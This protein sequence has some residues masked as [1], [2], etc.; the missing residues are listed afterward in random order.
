MLASATGAL[1][2]VERLERQ[3]KHAEA[4]EVLGRFDWR[5][6]PD[7]CLVGCS[8]LAALGDVSTEAAYGAAAE[9][10][11]DLAEFPYNYGNWLLRTGRLGEALT[12]YQRAVQRSPDHAKAQLNLGICAFNLDKFQLAEPALTRALSNFPDLAE[13]RLILARTCAK[14]DQP[15]RA[16]ALYEQYLINRPRDVPALL[17]MGLL[18]Q[19]YSNFSLALRLVAQAFPHGT[20]YQ[21]AR[22]FSM[23]AELYSSN[24]QP[25]Q[26]VDCFREALKIAP[27]HPQLHFA[28]LMALH[29]V[30]NDDPTEVI[31]AVREFGL[32]NCV[33]RPRIHSTPPDPDRRIRVGL[34]SGSFRR[35]PVGWLTLRAFEN[36]D[37]ERFELVAFESA[38][39]SDVFNKRFRACCSEW[40]QVGR[41][42]DRELADF[43]AGQR[44]D[45]LFELAGSGVGG[46]ILAMAFKP[47][48]IIIK[49]VGNQYGSSG[50]LEIDYFLTDD[51]E[52]PPGF[53]DDFAEELIRMPNGYAVYEPPDYAPAV[54]PLPALKNGFVRFASFNNVSKIN[55]FSV[56]LWARVMNAVPDSQLVLK[57]ISL[58][59]P[60]IRASFE[61]R[62]AVH[63]IA[64]HRLEFRQHT[65]HEVLLNE[66]NEVDIAIDPHPYTGGL[67]TCEALWMGVPVLT[68]PGRT[69]SSRHAATHLSNVG[70]SD[71]LADS[72]DGFVALA[73]RWAGDLE[74]LAA[75]RAGLRERMARSP[76]VDGP[77][78]GAEL[79][80]VLD[81]V[82]RRWCAERPDTVPL[83]S[84]P[85]RLD[86]LPLADVLSR[87]VSPMPRA[88]LQAKGANLAD[89]PLVR[90]IGAVVGEGELMPAATIAVLKEEI[91]SRRPTTIFQ[92]GGGMSVAVLAA[93]QAAARPGED[94]R[95]ICVVH[96]HELGERTRRHL[97][98]AGITHADVHLAPVEWLCVHHVVTFSYGLFPGLIEQALGGRRPDMVIVDGPHGPLLQLPCPRFPTVPMLRASLDPGTPVYM[99]G[100]MDPAHAMTAREWSELKYMEIDGILPVDSGLCLA[101]TVAY[102][103]DRRNRSRPS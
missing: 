89:D 12:Q 30:M 52:S 39:N 19:E 62:F 16:S 67:T 17:E 70:L 38:E 94:V 76:L 57:H 103:I 85:I 36:L 21:R 40:H 97:E 91:L 50:L 73:K 55:D 81:T 35:H 22:M 74:G 45:I 47:A 102:T 34:Y 63:G 28:S 96:T 56:E 58:G 88:D 10:W 25:R 86:L 78:F 18:L 13:I 71:W 65:P 59:D 3:G 29:Y 95:L 4:L 101:R 92:Y 26:S 83:R 68:L 7:L 15:K 49:W 43:I 87:A 11:P 84:A 69:F 99:T 42:T 90:K 80:S 6:D 79:G 93:I 33:F 8:L 46:K 1:V 61:Q 5:E 98:A 27:D 82:W 41:L 48:P 66:Y 100:A 77:A 32:R 64:A 60:A 37:P 51:V 54:G 44:I 20:P 53:D 14:L 2:E 23:M 9:R 31:E 75:L 24:A 72:P